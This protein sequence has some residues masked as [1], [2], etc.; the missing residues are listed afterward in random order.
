[1][2]C[3][4]RQSFVIILSSMLSN[5]FFSSIRICQGCPLSFF[6]CCVDILSHALYVAT[7]SSILDLYRPASGAMSI[8]Y[9][10]FAC[11]PG[12]YSKYRSLLQD[13]LSILLG[14]RI[15]GELPQINDHIQ[16]KNQAPSH[17]CHPTVLGVIE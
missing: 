10:L 5:F 14:F 2:I 11:R 3:V 13:Y 7:R 9:L 15:A 4:C 1:M 6:I 8:F 12:I 17:T 16:P